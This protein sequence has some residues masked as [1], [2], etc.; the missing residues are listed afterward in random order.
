[1]ANKLEGFMS[2]DLAVHEQASLAS[3][4][5]SATSL[6]ADGG[7]DQLAYTHPCLTS[8][9]EQELLI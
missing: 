9:Q 6:L 4:N 5:H 1:M 8:T 7:R 2:T 3:I